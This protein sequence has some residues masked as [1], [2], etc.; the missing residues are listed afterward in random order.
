ME[1]LWIVLGAA[2]SLFAAYSFFKAGKFKVTASKE[3]MLQAGFGWLE[4]QP[5]GTARVIGLLEL[6]GAIGVVV[7]PI[8]YYLGF[9]WSIW[10]AVAA[11]T[12]LALVMVAATLLHMVR[13]EGKYTNKMTLSLLAVS[14]V[15]AI[16]WAAI[17]IS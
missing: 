2:S 13:G 17:A 7:A 12:G 4:K 6:L 9:E 8:G 14:L 16:S 11:A 5:V 10:F 3:T 15:A 1:I